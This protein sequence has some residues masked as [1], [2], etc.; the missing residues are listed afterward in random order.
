[1]LALALIYAAVLYFIGEPNMTVLW[2]AYIPE[3]ELDSIT[4]MATGIGALLGFGVGILFE[5]NRVR[6]RADGPLGK[7]IARYALGII[8]TVIIWRGLGA[9]LPRDPLWL[10]LPLRIFRYALVTLW[11][12]YFAPL[13]FVR[14]RLADADPRPEMSLRF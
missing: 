4:Q 14:L 12:S 6:F 11:A 7:R 13:V 3:A 1:V 5:G 9:I 8:V 2:A 10:A